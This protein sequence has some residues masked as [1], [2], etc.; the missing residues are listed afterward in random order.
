MSSIFFLVLGRRGRSACDGVGRRGSVVTSVSIRGSDSL[1]VVVGCF[2]T[3]P[4]LG[5]ST[6]V[7]REC[8]DISDPIRGTG[9]WLDEGLV[10]FARK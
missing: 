3:A 6:M 9:K 2:E 4:V 10:Q 1:I 8:W 5:L 7:A